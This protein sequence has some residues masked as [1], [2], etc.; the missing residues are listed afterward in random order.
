MVTWLI[1]N[2]Q[3]NLD[4]DS[5]DQEIPSREFQALTLVMAVATLS[6]MTSW[7]R[8][9]WCMW[10]TPVAVVM[11]KALTTGKQCL[12]CWMGCGVMAGG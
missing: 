2:P 1:Q 10:W 5:N 3:D 7:M 12:V 4:S 11:L 8:T 6:S 9:V